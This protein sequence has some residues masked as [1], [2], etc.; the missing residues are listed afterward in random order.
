MN[1]NIKIIFKKLIKEY[2]KETEEITEQEQA[3][4]DLNDILG[5]YFGEYVKLIESNDK[6]LYM[7][8]ITDFETDKKYILTFDLINKNID[9]KNPSGVSILSTEYNP[10]TIGSDLSDAIKADNKPA[11]PLSSMDMNE[12][13]KLVLRRLFKFIA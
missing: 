13:K 1:R 2:L 8:K 12:S 4:I 5:N 3:V 9:L 11:S 10:K 6:D 7:I